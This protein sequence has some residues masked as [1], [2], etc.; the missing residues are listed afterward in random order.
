MTEDNDVLA[1]T[2]TI[3][4]EA[5]NQLHGGR[6][7]VACV[8]VNRVR[9]GRWPNTVHDVCHQAQQFSCWNEGDPNKD[10]IDK[11]S[12]EKNETWLECEA[13]AKAAI[14]GAIDVTF[15]SFHY[16]TDSIEAYWS[17]GLTPVIQIGSHVFFN[18]IP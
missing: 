2:G 4:G 1:L 6:V 11:A 8:V 3:Y 5:R 7:A 12:W 9:S 18:N 10:A 17:K 14:A 13:I 15:G 16:H